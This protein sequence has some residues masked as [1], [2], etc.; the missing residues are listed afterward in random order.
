MSLIT[1]IKYC[2]ISRNKTRYKNKFYALSQS[3][4]T[5]NSTE[6][7]SSP[8]STSKLINNGRVGIMMPLSVTFVVFPF[9]NFMKA[10]FVCCVNIFGYNNFEMITSS[11]FFNKNLFVGEEDD[12]NGEIDEDR[13]LP[14]SSPK[15]YATI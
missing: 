14:F 12:Y 13:W 11:N 1:C 5:S 7:T 15:P 6:W 9:M 4:T 3:Y 10:W 2:H 8:I